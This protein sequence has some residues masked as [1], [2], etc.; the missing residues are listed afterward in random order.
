MIDMI[1]A[2][3]REANTFKLLLRSIDDWKLVAQG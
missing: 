2:I 1:N 3:E